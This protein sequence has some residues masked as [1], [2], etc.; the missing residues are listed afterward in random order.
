VHAP[1]LGGV[2]VSLHRVAE[3]GSDSFEVGLARLIPGHTAAVVGHLQ[4]RLA[5]RAAAGDPHVHGT[6]V[7]RVLRELADRLEGMRLRVGDDRDRVPLVA[8]LER[9]GGG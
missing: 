4:K 7:D 1:S 2:E 8:D 3:V 9:A 6:R 5:L